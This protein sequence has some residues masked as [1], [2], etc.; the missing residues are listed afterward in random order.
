[1]DKIIQYIKSIDKD[2]LTHFIC[3]MII[4]FVTSCVV[5]LFTQDVCM[6]VS[7]GWL[8]G[9]LFGFYKELR[10]SFTGD[11]CSSCDWLADQCGNTVASLI[12]V[13]LMI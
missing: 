7:L 13:F 1:M 8:A 9:F 6:V 2:K 11:D 5:R 3:V 12:A 10:D 4:N